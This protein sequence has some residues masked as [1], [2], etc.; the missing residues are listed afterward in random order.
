MGFAYLDTDGTNIQLKA[1]VV[2]LDNTFIFENIILF[3]ED[4]VAGSDRTDHLLKK[5]EAAEAIDEDF[6]TMLGWLKERYPS[7]FMEFGDYSDSTYKHFHLYFSSHS[8]D[9]YDADRFLPLKLVNMRVLNY[10]STVSSSIYKSSRFELFDYLGLKISDIGYCGTGGQE[11]TIEA[12]II[13]PDDSTGFGNGVRLVSFMMRPDDLIECGYVLRKD[14]WRTDAHVYQRLADKKRIRAIREFVAKNEK[15]FVNN[16]IVGLPDDAK[17]VDEEGHIVSIDDISGYEKYTLKLKKE[18]N[19]ICIIDGQHRIYAHHEGMDKHEPK[20]EILRGR[21]HLLVTGF[22]FPKYMSMRER[23]EFESDAFIEINKEAKKVSNSVLLYIN[24]WKNQ[25][26]SSGVARRIIEELNRKGVFKG[27]FQLSEVEPARIKTTSIISFALNRFVAIDRPE[28]DSTLLHFWDGSK[29]LLSVDSIKTDEGGRAFDEYIEFCASEINKFFSALRQV[30]KEDWD[31]PESKIFSV[32]SINGFLLAFRGSLP[33][34]GLVEREAYV[35]SFG[36]LK[37]DFNKSSTPGEGFPY[38]SSQYGKFSREILRD[39]FGIV[40]ELET[41]EESG[42]RAP[43]K[44]SL[45]E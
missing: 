32:T 21:L 15:T 19:S 1:R 23:A 12:T 4:T 20:I 29:E 35:K 2:E 8:L 33:V 30:R 3:C 14:N 38:S 16:V 26:S 6:S 11:N 28:D 31:N 22:I 18:Y 37:T 40:D 5:K 42:K 44:K 36:K 9:E 17:I 24:M 45:H 27:L 13:T 25:H 43:D 7:K 39:C 34:Y 41:G 10:F